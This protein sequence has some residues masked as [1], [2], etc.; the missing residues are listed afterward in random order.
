MR[1]IITLLTDFGYADPYVASMKGVILG[2]NP[3][4]Q[5]VDISHNVTPQNINEAAFILK[6]SYPFFPKGTIHV[7][8]VDP[9]VGSNRSIFAV[10]SDSAIFLAPDNAVLKYVFDD[11]PVEVYQITNRDYFRDNV[12]HTFHGR[13]IFAPVAAHISKGISLEILG[14]PFA[15]YVTGKVSKPV[16]DANEKITGEVVYIDRFGN[17]ITNIEG[18]LL[19]GRKQIQLHVK[20]IT[21]RELS[22]RYT[23]VPAGKPLALIGSGNTL[24]I[25]VH[26]GNASRQLEFGVG[27][28][29]IISIK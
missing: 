22:S 5:I 1:L 19:A 25:S 3:D 21:I 6:R 16:V 18:H 4:V 12:S 26:Q 9:G 28:K 2:I 15:D 7:V 13:D 20:S 23:D 17:G 8:V 24:E 14:R 29:I 10:K 27:D 11:G